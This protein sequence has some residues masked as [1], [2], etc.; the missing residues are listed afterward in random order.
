M[1]V[2]LVSRQII[3]GCPPTSSPRER[4]GSTCQ[5]AP[6]TSLP[7]TETGMIRC[8]RVRTSEAS[9]IVGQEM[10]RR[11]ATETSRRARRSEVLAGPM[12]S[13]I[14]DTA[15]CLPERGSAPSQGAET[16]LRSK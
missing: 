16:P 8:G 12:F 14:A 2:V 3:D 6:S 10:L 11:V 1:S 13:S 5:G 15:A 4:G 9:Y 7:K